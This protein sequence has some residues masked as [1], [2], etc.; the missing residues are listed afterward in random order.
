LEER[1]NLNNNNNN[2]SSTTQIPIISSPPQLNIN[3]LSL[4]IT[5][6]LRQEHRLK[7]RWT[8]WFLN[9]DRELTWLERLKKVCTIE[10]AEAFWALV[11]F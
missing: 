10:S 3:N 6:K 1:Q 2:T 4:S 5:S 7:T 9:S 11:Y 8:F